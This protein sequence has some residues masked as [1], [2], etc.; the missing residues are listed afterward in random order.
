MRSFNCFSMFLA[1]NGYMIY[2][3]TDVRNCNCVLIAY[4]YYVYLMQLRMR[5]C[6][7]PPP[8]FQVAPQSYDTRSN[9]NIWSL[10]KSLIQ[11][12]RTAVNLK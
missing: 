1:G 3:G 2:L 7:S 9:F 5:I 4:M 8:E 12:S 11:K 10:K 6:T